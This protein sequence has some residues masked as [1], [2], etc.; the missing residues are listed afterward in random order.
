MSRTLVRSGLEQ[1]ISQWGRITPTLGGALA[2]LWFVAAAASQEYWDIP[3]APPVFNANTDVGYD[4]VPYCTQP[5]ESCRLLDARNVVWP[6][7]WG[8]DFGG[9]L[10]G[11]CRLLNC[12][13]DGEGLVWALVDGVGENTVQ[14][15]W[16]L[17]AAAKC[18]ANA[19]PSRADR[20]TSWTAMPTSMR[21]LICKSAPC[22]PDKR[23]PSPPTGGACC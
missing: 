1:R 17:M 23:S 16:M 10:Y 4:T 11:N 22:H 5:R 3:G 13:H 14:V 15:R 8:N 18:T 9:Y 20:T 2:L 7:F 6:G 19:H 12:A 21:P